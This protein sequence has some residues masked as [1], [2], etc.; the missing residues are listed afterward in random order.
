MKNR[1]T[2]D[3][4]DITGARATTTGGAS[5]DARAT[6]VDRDST[7]RDTAIIDETTSA[8]H[9]PLLEPGAQGIEASKPKLEVAPLAGGRSGGQIG[10]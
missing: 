5:M 10:A 4:I 3:G 7:A 8:N 2:T 1:A 6:M 9:P